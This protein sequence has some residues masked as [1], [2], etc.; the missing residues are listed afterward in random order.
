MTLESPSDAAF[1]LLGSRLLYN[2]MILFLNYNAL[3]LGP[4]D[5]DQD[6]SEHLPKHFLYL[7]L[8]FYSWEEHFS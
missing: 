8:P 4:N 5:H 2:Y 1:A 7:I 3:Y 6:E